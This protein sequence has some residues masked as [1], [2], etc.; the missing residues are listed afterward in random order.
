MTD[1]R[2]ILLH[3]IQDQLRRHPGFRIGDLYKMLHQIC[4]GG[5]HL[6]KNRA[7]ARKALQEEWNNTEKIPKGEPLIEIIDPR[8]EVMRINLRIFKKIGG[9]PHRLF[10]VFI[11]SAEQAKPDRERLILYW[12]YI[13]DM[14]RA[15]DIPFSKALLEDFWIDKGKEGF[16]AIRHSESYIDANR[17]SY[18]VVMKNLWEGFEE[19]E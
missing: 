10:D 18:R 12:G 16:P 2:D 19:E 14:M 17:P 6:L 4:Y 3:I 7:K 11:R 15:G 8:S 13:M 5:E 1:E 9:T